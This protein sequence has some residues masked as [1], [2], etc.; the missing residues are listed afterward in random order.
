MAPD[1]R[2][3][4]S[5]VGGDERTAWVHDQQ[6]DR[7]ISSEGYVFDAHLS[8][9]GSSLF[10]LVARSHS[11]TERGGELWISD[12]RSGQ[13][14][15]GLPGI[16]MVNFSLSPDG[17]RVAY[18]S[19]DQ[20]GKHRIWLASLDH[21]FTPRQIG[22]GA[23][24]AWPTYGPSGKI[25]FQASQ[26]DVDYLY[27]MNDDGTQ[28][29]KIV[30]E[31]IIYLLGVSPDERFVA[32][33]RATKGEDNPTVIEVLPL[34]SGPAAR[35]CS[36]WCGVDW[37][38]D[39]KNFYFARPSMKGGSQWRTYVI[40]LTHGNLPSLPAKGIQSDKDLPNLPA[41]QFVEERIYPGP[42]SSIYSFSKRNSHWNLY[43]IPVP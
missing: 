11:E 1:G 30:P 28:R 34:A 36:G 43:R 23:G 15:K 2:S 20:D 26:G 39:G 10:Y 38:R 12:L 14:S 3:F 33:R 5:S 9:D 24:E 32:V 8:P 41:L 19:R 25:Y 16:A 22:S 35:I 29:E 13:A 18:D 27:R 42:H 7:Q 37:T 6:G 40:P 4:V 21:R 31:P 17:K